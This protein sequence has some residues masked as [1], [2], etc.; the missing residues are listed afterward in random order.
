MIRSNWF[1]PLVITVSLV[2][3]SL[4]AFTGSESPIR[5]VV[6]IWFMLLCPGM[7]YV[8]LLKLREPLTELTFGVALSIAINTIVA[9][10]MLYAGV[11]SP[12]LS[13]VVVVI[14]TGCGVVLQVADA[15]R[16]SKVQKETVG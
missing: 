1:W 13:L 15:L 9:A 7:A 5:P 2:A 14:I 12:S 11:W 16:V 4:L 3:T 8:R 6:V 10:M